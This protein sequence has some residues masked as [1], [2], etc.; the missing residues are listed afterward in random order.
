V[1][2]LEVSGLGWEKSLKGTRLKLFSSAV[3][4]KVKEWNGPTPA[5]YDTETAAEV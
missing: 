1:G 3:T 5:T 2:Y 4:L